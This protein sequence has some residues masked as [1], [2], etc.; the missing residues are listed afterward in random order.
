[1][2]VKLVENASRPDTTGLDRQ[3]NTSQVQCLKSTPI[4]GCQNF[5]KHYP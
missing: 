2:H 5:S 1:M 4:L 3:A